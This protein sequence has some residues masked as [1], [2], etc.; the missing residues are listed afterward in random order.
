MRFLPPR[1]PFRRHFSRV[2]KAWFPAALVAFALA[3][4]PALAGN[5]PTEQRG[6]A[7]SA[8]KPAPEANATK[9]PGSWAEQQSALCTAAVHDAEAR[10]PVPGG[11]LGTIAKV[12]SGRPI[13]AMADVR[14]WP[15]TIDAD[16]RGYFFESKAAAVAW[17]KLALARGAVNF[18]DV[19][20]MQV[21]LQMHPGAFRSVDDAFDP[22][23]NVDY[24][25]RYLQ[26]LHDADANGNW[27]VAVGLYHSHT[28]L[29][30]AA[31]RDRVAAVGAGIVTGFGAPEP[32]YMRALR[33]GTLRLALA[34]GGVMVLHINRQP[35]L[36]AHPRLSACQLVAFLGADLPP[37]AQAAHHGCR[38][39]AG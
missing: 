25:A 23:A 4:V 7:D 21:D 22:A 18:M 2:Y 28:P 36:H 15:W 12:E 33:A 16:G 35:A 6:V 3:I 34:G 32:L 24:G 31:Y 27:Y 13:T 19:G 9:P 17:A 37:R 38:A 14:A 30:A 10:Y 29:L 8:A 1:A 11:L 39:R 20:C 26:R 5:I